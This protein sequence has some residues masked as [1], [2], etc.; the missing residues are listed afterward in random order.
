MTL[1]Y[2]TLA[3]GCGILACHWL[4]R[5]GL[6]GCHTSG[7]GFAG[8]VSLAAL[9]TILL[10]GQRRGR[11]IGG[12]ALMLLLGAWRYHARPLTLCAT[13]A[14]LAFYHRDSERIPWAT[15]E[16]VV[17]GYPDVRDVQTYYRVRAESLTIAGQSWP[18]KGDVLIQASRFPTYAYGDRLRASGSLQT[19]PT[20]DDFDYRAYLARQGIYSLLRRA[21]VEKIGQGEGSPFWALLYGLRA[22]GSALLNRVLPEP[23]AGLANGMLLGI[24]SGIPPAVDEAFQAT[25]TSHVIVISG[26]NVALLSGLL[27]GLFRRLLGKRRAALP[28]AAG[29]VLYILLVG[30][31]PAAVRAGLMGILYVLG[32]FLGRESTAFV[33][34]FASALFMTMFNPLMLWDVGFQLSFMATLGLMLFTPAL[35]S[36]CASLLSRLLATRAQMAMGLLNEA[37][38][39]TLAAQITTLPLILYYFGRLSLVSL[40]ANFFILPAQ[41]PIMA[42]GM[43][44]LAAGLLWEPAGRVLAILPWLLLT[45]TTAVVRLAASLPLATVETGMVGRMVAPLYYVGL[46]GAMGWRHLALPARRLLAGAVATLLPLWLGLTAIAALPDGRLHLIFIPGDG[47]EAALV[48]T[49]EGRRVWIWDGVGDEEALARAARPF[50]SGWRQGVDVVLGPSRPAPGPA[51]Q[52][53]EPSQLPSGTR[54][55]LG[56]NLMLRWYAAGGVWALEYGSFRTLL[57]AT[58]TPDAQMA[59]LA[60]ESAADLQLTVLKAPGP[61]TGAWPLP[62]FLAATWPQVILWPMETSY[63]PAVV[64]LLQARSTARVPSDAIVEVITDGQ[65]MWLHQWSSMGHR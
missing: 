38:I 31:D 64:E 27:L 44:T 65:Q 47:S 46:F 43:A 35:R 1:V 54:L 60:D 39:V 52:S 37:L 9:T 30:A 17:V 32:I 12:L 5:W 10:R 58:M 8:L 41:P 15:I 29:I 11:W 42:G 20:F 45:Y 40:A 2:L 49:P 7:W 16:G 63:P 26:S 18:V 3:W 6:I 57:P 50:L 4:W 51:G 34:L 24:E 22:R 23:A 28:T 55:R 56:D 13:P 33:S 19:P 36:R 21:R 62:A 53:I 25:G 59:L 48:V 61:A 14:D